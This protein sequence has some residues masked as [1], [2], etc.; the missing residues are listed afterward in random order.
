LDVIALSEDAAKLANEEQSWFLA[1]QTLAALRSENAELA[2]ESAQLAQELTGEGLYSM[3]AQAYFQLSNNKNDEASTLVKRILAIDSKQVDAL[4]LQ[5]QIATVVKEY[6]LASVSYKAYLAL[7]PR[8][9]IVQLLLADAL[10][11]AGEFE[12]A[13]QYADTILAS[14]STQPFA[15]YIKALARFQEQDF[16]NASKHAELALSADFNQF[17]LKL[18]AGASAFHLKN[19]EQSYHHLS[20]IV[21]YLPSD[22]QARR[23]LA[24]S[25]LELGLVSEINSTLADFE[26]TDSEKKGSEESSQFLSSLSFKLLE[27][28]AIDEAKKLVNQNEN[29]GEDNAEHNAR[30]GILKLMMNDPSGMQD[31]KDAV[32][33]NPELVE[34]EFAIAFA[35]LQT[36]YVEQASTIAAKWKSKYPKKA[37]GFNLMASIAIKQ[38]NYEKAEQELKESLVLEPD[39]IFALIEQLRIARQQKNNDLSKQ[40]ADYLI[41]LYPN[42]NKVLRQY[43]G[44]YQNEMAL[45]KLSA[46]HELDKA[47]IKKAILLSEALVS[48]QKFKQAIKILTPLEAKDKLPKSYW[49]LLS[50]IYKQQQDVNKMQSTLEKWLKASPYHLEPIVLLTDLHASKRNYERALSVVKR[51]LQTHDDNVILQLVKMQLLLNSKQITPAKELYKALVVKDLNEALKQGL[52]G[53][54]FLLE[55]NFVQAVPKLEQFYQT[56]PSNQNAAYLAGAY[57]GNKDKNKAIGFLENHLGKVSQNGRLKTMLA[58]LYLNDDDAKAI[59]H[60]VEIT[61]QQPKNV[62]ANNNLAW[63]YSE[64]GQTEKALVHAKL[65]FEVAPKNPN[66]VDTYAK[67]L[68]KKG[69]K[70]AALKHAEIASSLANGKDTDIALNL[71]EAF[72][73]N[74]RLSEAKALLKETIVAT[75]EQKERKSQLLTRL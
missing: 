13:E 59:A 73:A 65:A 46:A 3:L 30:Q 45:A 58:G 51:G 70:I 8:S 62:I 55:S 9:R 60:Y 64:Q 6:N 48:L 52:L 43:F 4:M 40:R 7:Q 72:I 74:S 50:L 41:T 28:G 33:L 47:D 71:A 21:K 2:K 35:S 53:R 36:G 27:L 10:L 44:T 38:E 61:K 24:V 12:E 34:A 75:D 17:S 54:I 56:Y 19:W 5:G 16:T 63:L 22:H 23:M 32:K 31:L 14:L 11:K 69:D 20:N 25:Q 66:V 29:L 67:V 18:V 49:Q 57:L 68:L 26:S 37:G 1:Y 15:N 39:N 42:N